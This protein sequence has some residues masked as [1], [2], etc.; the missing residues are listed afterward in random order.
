MCICP[1]GNAK[2]AG[3]PEVGELQVVVLLIDEQ[4]L[5]LQVAVQDAVRV[6]VR[7]ALQHLVQVQLRTEHASVT[8]CHP[9]VKDRPQYCL[10]NIDRRSQGAFTMQTTSAVA[11][12]P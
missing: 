5:W 2:C 11:D 9:T 10:L 6:A 3:Q 1:D 7:N 4:V 8:V 12:S